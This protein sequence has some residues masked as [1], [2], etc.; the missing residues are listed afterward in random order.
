MTR[1][2]CHGETLDNLEE[3]SKLRDDIRKANVMREKAFSIAKSQ[4]I[5]ELQ[6]S[7]SVARLREDSRRRKTL[8]E[9][10][11][12]KEDTPLDVEEVKVHLSINEDDDNTIVQPLSD[13]EH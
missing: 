6:K 12:A 5:T 3:L 7:A 8:R 13:D 9:K 4:T 1:F 2:G 10:F 11:I